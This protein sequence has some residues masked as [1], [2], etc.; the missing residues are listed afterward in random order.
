MPTL[1]KYSMYMLL[2]AYSWSLFFHESLFTF[3]LNTIFNLT[4]FNWQFSNVKITRQIDLV[5]HYLA[6]EWYNLR[7]FSAHFSANLLSW[8]TFYQ[9]SSILILSSKE[10][11]FS[12]YV[13]YALHNCSY[14]NCNIGFMWFVYHYFLVSIVLRMSRIL[15]FQAVP[16]CQLVLCCPWWWKI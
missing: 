9:L 3:W 11:S 14:F 5:L 6:Y 4:N 15:V 16:R 8:L 12:H 7:N 10:I 13:V 1:Q 2:S